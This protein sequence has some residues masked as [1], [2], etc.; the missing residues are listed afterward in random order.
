MIITKVVLE[1]LVVDQW[2]LGTHATVLKH[3][4]WGQ[5]RE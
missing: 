4:D 3:L 5:R 2:D 1:F